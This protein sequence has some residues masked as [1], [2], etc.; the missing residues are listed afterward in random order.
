MVDVSKDAESTTAVD[1][2]AKGVPD[3]VRAA[4][5]EEKEEFDAE[6][7]AQA[8]DAREWVEHRPIPGLDYREIS[9]ADW[10]K[11]GVNVE[12]QGAG[13]VRWDAGNDWR[14]PRGMLDFLTEGQ[15]Q[16]H[17]LNDGRFKVVDEG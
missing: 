3:E 2:N 17:I 13:Y 12:E 7:R 11:A 5:L 16:Q 6:W 1:P 14:I 8:P 9:I 4:K 15:F 10:Q